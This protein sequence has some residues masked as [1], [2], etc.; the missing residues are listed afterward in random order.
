ME[1]KVSTNLKPR[2]PILTT[3]KNGPRDVMIEADDLMNG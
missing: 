1:K 3:L 2:F